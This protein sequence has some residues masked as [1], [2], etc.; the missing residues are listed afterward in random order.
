MGTG[1]RSVRQ[2]HKSNLFAVDVES[3]PRLLA[4][5]NPGLQER[6]DELL[7]AFDRMPAHLAPE[8]EERARRFHGLIREEAGQ[9][10]DAFDEVWHLTRPASGGSWAIAGIQQSQ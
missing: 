7:A 1:R 10:A 8:D 4:D 3:I 2:R 5:A 9:P 6:R